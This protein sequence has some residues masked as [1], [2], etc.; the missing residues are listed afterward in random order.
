[1]RAKIEDYLKRAETVKAL[2][3][4]EKEGKLPHLPL[5]GYIHILVQGQLIDE[6]INRSIFILNMIFVYST[7][8]LIINRK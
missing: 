2:V 6:S 4:S 1:M 3:K 5:Y 7:R 8:K